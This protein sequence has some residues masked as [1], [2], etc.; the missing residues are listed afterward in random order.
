[1]GWGYVLI[2]DTAF[3]R[4]VV[5]G[6][7]IM[8]GCNVVGTTSDRLV[9]EQLKLDQF[10]TNHIRAYFNMGLINYVR[11]NRRLLPCEAGSVNFFID[12][13]GEVY[14]CNGMECRY[15][16]ASMGN[17]RSESFD[18]L[19]GSAQAMRVREQVSRC[20]KNCWMVGTV[21]P[22]MHRHLYKP[23]RWVVKNKL[24]S[25]LNQ[26]PSMACPR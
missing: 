22:V 8:A 1:M 25:V 13:H 19:W 2:R 24:R 7:S 10:I 17:I 9:V 15:W 12:P 4:P 21:S 20:P 11:G 26:D 14:P 18:A 5:T 16:K 23:L 3:S 6:A